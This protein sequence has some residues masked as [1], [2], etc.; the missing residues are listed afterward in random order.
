VNAA[1]RRRLQLITVGHSPHRFTDI[2]GETTFLVFSSA[3][4]AH[5][6]IRENL[7]RRE[8]L[9]SV[10]KDPMFAIARS[11]AEGEYSL[12]ECDAMAVLTLALGIGAEY[13]IMD[14]RPG[15]PERLLPVSQ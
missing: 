6:F 2:R 13:L 8:P 1:A 12:V 15:E 14:P 10:S 9:Q 3:Y 7:E 11:L 4:R 5:L